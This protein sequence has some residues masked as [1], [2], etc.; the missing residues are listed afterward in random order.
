[1]FVHDMWTGDATFA[2]ETNFQCHAKIHIQT[3]QH[4]YGMGGLL[5]YCR[6]VLCHG[7]THYQSV[8]LSGV[9]YLCP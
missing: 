4:D 1:M 6:I 8:G 5:P 3:R 9:Y 2:P 7:R